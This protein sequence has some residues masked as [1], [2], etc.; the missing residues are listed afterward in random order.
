MILTESGMRNCRDS[1][2]PV[3]VHVFSAGPVGCEGYRLQNYSGEYFQALSK[4]TQDVRLKLL[5][6][7]GQRSRGSSF[8]W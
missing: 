1:F 6:S 8:F 5:F 3:I 2:T 7:K 4:Y